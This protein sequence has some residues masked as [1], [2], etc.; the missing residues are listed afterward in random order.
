MRKHLTLRSTSVTRRSISTSLPLLPKLVTICNRCKGTFASRN[1]LFLHLR[2]DCWKAKSEPTV[3]PQP[4]SVLQ[5]PSPKTTSDSPKATS[6]VYAQSTMVCPQPTS[7]LS[8]SL[9]TQLVSLKSTALAVTKST[10]S[11]YTPI[12][13]ARNTPL[14]MSV[15]VLKGPKLSICL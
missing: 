2:N 12:R 8:G 6:D 13:R 3:Y 11:G 14:L 4:T 9:A 5:E 1:A 15:S 7:V 10:P